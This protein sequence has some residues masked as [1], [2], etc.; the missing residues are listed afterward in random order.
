MTELFNSFS[1]TTIFIENL[2]FMF[3]L[4]SGNDQITSL[5][6]VVAKKTLVQCTDVITESSIDP[7]TLARKLYS[8]EVFPEDT[9]KRVRDM[10]TRDSNEGRLQQILDHLIDRV[11]HKPNILV[12][13][14]DILNDLGRQDL[15]AL[16]VKKYKGMLYRMLYYMY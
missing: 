12:S 6:P 10:S 5:D 3:S 15:A 4:E 16:I 13:F 11:R 7:F 9:Y 14:L 1:H 8:N 2:F